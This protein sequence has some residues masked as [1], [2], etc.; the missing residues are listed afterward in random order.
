MLKQNILERVVENASK[1]LRSRIFSACQSNLFLGLL[2][3]T[4]E[5]IQERCRQ[6]SALGASDEIIYQA[7][8]RTIQTLVVNTSIFK[9]PPFPMDKSSSYSDETLKVIHTTIIR[10]IMEDGTAA[11][12]IMLN[13]DVVARKE[14]LD[15][16]CVKH[17]WDRFVFRERVT[18]Y[19]D[20]VEGRKLYAPTARAIAWM[21][22]EMMKGL[23]I[24]F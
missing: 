22:K 15:Q 14:E 17:E 20:I 1:Q 11:A 19:R 16:L 13:I 10:E 2:T 12:M 3:S 18:L 9:N 23:L 4:D 7:I 6:W 24:L 5:I 8:Y 21:K